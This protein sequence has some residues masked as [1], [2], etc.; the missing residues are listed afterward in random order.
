MFKSIRYKIV[1]IFVLLTLSMTT[2]IGAFTITN[3]I[4][5]YNKE[6]SVMMEDVFEEDLIYQLKKMAE[7]GPDHEGVSNAISTYIGPL[8]I[9]TY[10][11]YCILDGGS[12]KVLSSSDY[13]NSQNMEISDN[14]IT[15]MTGRIGNAVITNKTYMDYA[16][17]ITVGNKCKYIVQR[18]IKVH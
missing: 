17:P 9:D 3:I 12:G 10:R 8:G 14:I 7:T 15:A 4:D 2:V 5:Y 6:F 13:V 1:L 16:V 18:T 11:F